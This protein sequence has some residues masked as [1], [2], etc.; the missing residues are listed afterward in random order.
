MRP[1]SLT[2]AALAVA[3]ALFILPAGLIMRLLGIDPM[4]MR[5]DTRSASEW[6]EQ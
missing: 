5:P 3:Y 1:P 4:R 6:E 2:R